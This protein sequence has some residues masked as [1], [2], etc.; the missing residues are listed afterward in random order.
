[1]A[2]R[3]EAGG[4]QLSSELVAEIDAPGPVAV[5]SLETDGGSFGLYLDA[6]ESET[7]A[8]VAPAEVVTVPDPSSLT[9]DEIRGMVARL[10]DVERARMGQMEAHGKQRSSA[11]EVLARRRG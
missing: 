4:F 8:D 9:V 3:L 6:P 11:L 7:V 2:R 1:M 5:G 10:S